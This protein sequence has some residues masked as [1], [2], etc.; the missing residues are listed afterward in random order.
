MSIIASCG[1]LL[2]K[3]E[4][5]GTTIAV[6]DYCRDGDKAIAYPT[7]CN[8]CLKWYRKK[9]LELKTEEEQKCWINSI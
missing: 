6:K 8:K 7:L 2:T 5:L 9:K 3:E 4:G 1:H